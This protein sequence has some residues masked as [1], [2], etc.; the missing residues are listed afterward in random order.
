[1]RHIS[2]KWQYRHDACLPNKYSWKKSSFLKTPQNNWRSTPMRFWMYKYSRLTHNAV[3]S[4]NKRVIHK[5]TGRYNLFIIIFLLWV[6]GN[7]HV[8]R[9][10]GRPPP[11]L[12]RVSV[13]GCGNV[14][15]GPVHFEVR[16]GAV[17]FVVHAQ[18]L[19]EEL[20]R[21]EHSQIHL[22]LKK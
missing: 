1:M 4:R 3:S 19:V 16:K 18:N 10:G 2:F 21:F 15:L 17:D 6:S 8:I 22:K 12:V 20:A 5:K 11:T 9:S 14:P 7:L 13:L